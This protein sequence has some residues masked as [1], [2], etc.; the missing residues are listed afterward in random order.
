MPDGERLTAMRV[1]GFALEKALETIHC[2]G[3]WALKGSGVGEVSV[4]KVAVGRPDANRRTVVC[5]VSDVHQRAVLAAAEDIAARLRE[6]GCAIVSTI[7]PQPGVGDHDLALEHRQTGV[8]CAGQYSSELKHRTLPAK[9]ELMRKDCAKV[10][11]AAVAESSKWLGQL[12]IVA[13]ISSG[14][15]IRSRAEL[16]VR[17]RPREDALN[18]WGWAGRP[19]GPPAPAAPAAPAA[20]AAPAAPAAPAPTAA[21]AQ[22]KRERGEPMAKKPWGEVW[23]SLR[24]FDVSWADEKVVILKDF[25]KEMGGSGPGCTHVSRE[26]PKHRQAP[27]MWRKGVHY[28][29]ATRRQE[30]RVRQGG[31]LKPWV[32]KRSALKSLYDTM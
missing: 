29:R 7:A 15:F 32:V 22:R 3:V 17:G 1:A 27:L 14:S 13:E 4:Q 28:D 19:C 26:L 20:L 9:R 16:V 23:A 24:K 18:V 10:W 5:T 25:Y 6:A 11:K 21:A 31:A 8:P 30:G 2:K 12:I